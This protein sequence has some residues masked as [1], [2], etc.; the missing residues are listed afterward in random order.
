M[1]P[2]VAEVHEYRKQVYETVVEAIETHPSLSD[3]G[4]LVNQDHPFWA[5]FMVRFLLPSVQPVLFSPASVSFFNPSIIS[6]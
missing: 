6:S 2:T 1:W 5:L 4:V 3:D